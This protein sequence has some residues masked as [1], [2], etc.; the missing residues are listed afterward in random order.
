MRKQSLGPHFVYIL[1]CSDKTLYTGITIDIKNR[2]RQH[3]GEIAGGAFYTRNKRPIKLVYQEE[4]QT[5]K[6]A[7]LREIAIKKL[8]RT[9][10]QKLIGN[11]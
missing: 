1:Q 3:N 11:Y 2:L 6:E 9:Q 7:I 8:S 5:L 4:Y 10:K